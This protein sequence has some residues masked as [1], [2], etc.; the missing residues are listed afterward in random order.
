MGAELM[1]RVLRDLE[2]HDKNKVDQPQEGISYAPKIVKSDF[3]IK[4]TEKS[5]ED[6]YNQSRALADMGKLYSFWKDT[7]VRFEK[8]LQP[9]SLENLC[10]DDKYPNY[11]PG[12]VISVKQGKTRL[13]CIKCLQGWI[14][15]ERFFYDKRKVMTAS[16]FY[17]G[18]MSNNKSQQHI[19]TIKS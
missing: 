19:F 10:L 12:Q 11:S 6:V 1:I 4:W 3:E 16:D 9:S 15:F 17:S 5:A 18:F 13:V 7:I 8:P 14:S 2:G